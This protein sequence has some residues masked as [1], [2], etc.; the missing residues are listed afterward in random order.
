MD[1]LYFL[2]DVI[3]K[4]EK[5]DLSKTAL[6]R[7]RFYSEDLGFIA[8]QILQP[9][10][11]SIVLN[12]FAYLSIFQNIPTGLATPIWLRRIRFYRHYLFGCCN[13]TQAAIKAGYSPRSASKQGYRL[14]KKSADMF[15]E[16]RASDRSERERQG[17]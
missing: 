3:N 5:Q 16:S 2:S 11:V 10:G 12:T 6:E 7:K 15:R 8:E 14:V 9:N 13:A 17:I 1:I 4:L